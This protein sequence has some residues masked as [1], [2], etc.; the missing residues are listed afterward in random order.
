MSPAAKAA[1]AVAAPAPVVPGQ[2][3][4]VA[5]SLNLILDEMASFF[6]ERRACIQAALITLL[7]KEHMFILGPPGTGKSMLIR[8]L[9]SRIE[10]STLFECL[11]SKTRPDAAILG[12]YNLPELRDKG[13]FHRKINGFLPS[14]N[15]AFIDEVGKMSPTLGHDMLAILNER[16][17]HEVNGGRSAKPVPLYS[18]FTAA[19]ELI[20]EESDDSA[21]LWDRLLVRDYVDYIQESGNFA[22]LL[23]GAASGPAPTT[24]TTVDFADLADAIDNVVPTIDVPIGAIETVLRLRDDLRSLEIMPSDRRWRQC[25]RLL[26]ASAFLNGRDA[27][28]DD[29]I[30]VLRYA[31]WDV[32]AQISPVERACL[33]LSNPVAEK[34]IGILDDVENISREIRDRKGQAIDARAAYGTEANGK[35]KVLVSE[36]GQLRQECIAAGRSTSKIDEVADK[37]AA[38]R[39]SIYV[40]CLDMDPASIR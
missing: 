22:V 25:V 30:H 37:I 20:V 6:L 3:H 15:F 12:P 16:L 11:M 5:V 8:D 34:C 23:Q 26:Q 28:D 4:P 13:D 32:P 9:I 33:S 35:V 21:A 17:Y 29:D 39:R 14:V 19:N 31:L 18:A 36:L 10:N 27:V 7:A 38:V 24:R 40:D 2:P 1:A